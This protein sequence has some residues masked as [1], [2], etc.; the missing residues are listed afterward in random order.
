MLT[1]YPYGSA[2]PLIDTV[3]FIVFVV[4]SAVVM[5]HTSI[6]YAVLKAAYSCYVFVYVLIQNSYSDYLLIYASVITA[7]LTTTGPPVAMLVVLRTTL[8][9]VV[10]TSRSMMPV[11]APDD[12]T[13]RA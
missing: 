4:I 3:G 5:V 7:L 10:P 13:S 1:I 2:V 11:V 6:E 8:V 9:P 12:V